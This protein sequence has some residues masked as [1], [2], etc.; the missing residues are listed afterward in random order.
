MVVLDPLPRPL[1]RGFFVGSTGV[2][3]LGGSASIRG[4]NLT[5][6]YCLITTG[7]WKGNGDNA[8][9]HFVAAGRGD[10]RVRSC[11]ALRDQRS[12]RGRWR[13]V[14]GPNSARPLGQLR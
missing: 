13:M 5:E 4:W 3:V 11:K 9:N 12:H 2:E 1:S 8:C 14:G 6:W 7:G 10:H